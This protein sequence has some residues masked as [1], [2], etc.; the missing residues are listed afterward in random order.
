MPQ[1]TRRQDRTGAV[2]NKTEILGCLDR[3]DL[4]QRLVITPL[5]DPAESVGPSSVDVRLGNQFIVMRREAFPLLNIRQ[6]PSLTKN[7]GRYQE[8]VVKR[9]GERFVLHPRQLVIGSTLEYV[10]LP[11][12]I[13]CYVIGKSSWGRMGLIIATA[14]KVDPGFRGCI[15]LEVVNEGEIPLV[16][17]PGIMIAQLV[18]QW[19]TPGT[20]YSGRYDCPIG[21]EFPRFVDD[22][23]WRFWLKDDP[24]GAL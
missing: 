19:M 3:P 18:L 10:Q 13:M 4:R 14:T 24:D 11:A 5:L 6:I 22:P 15:T 23:K 8:R 9:V 17:Y 1:R 16:L 2:L 21:P 20:R 7:L 12:D